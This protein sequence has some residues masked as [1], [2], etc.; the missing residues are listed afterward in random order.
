MKKSSASTNTTTEQ[1]F[2]RS[3][4]AGVIFSTK[5]A[6]KTLEAWI[7]EGAPDHSLVF[8]TPANLLRAGL[9]IV[10]AR[11][12]DGAYYKAKFKVPAHSDITVPYTLLKVLDLSTI[13]EKVFP[14]LIFFD[15]DNKRHKPRKIG[16]SGTSKVVLDA[17][18]RK[19]GETNE[20]ES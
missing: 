17:I 10:D 11:L 20:S 6:Y 2:S 8:D 18:N 12:V 13:E 7:H 3:N 1:S 19:K 5:G 9:P 16:T 14:G 4:V 15:V